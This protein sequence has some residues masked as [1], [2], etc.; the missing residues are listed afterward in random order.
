MTNSSNRIVVEH[1]RQARAS[2]P[3]GGTT[4]ERLLGSSRTVADIRRDRFGRGPETDADTGRLAGRIPAAA[5]IC[6]HVQGP[7]AWQ[8]RDEE[9]SPGRQ[10]RMDR[11]RY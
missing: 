10:L 6:R 5:R 3:A 8:G 4:D 7:A 2:I 11:R 1:H 9:L